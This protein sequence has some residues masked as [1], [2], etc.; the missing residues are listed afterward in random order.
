MNSVFLMGRLT[1]DPDLKSTTNGNS[2]CSFTIAV[3]RKYKNA[4]GE[5][6]A[7]FI[8]CQAWRATAENI[9]KY[10]GKG[11]KIAVTGRLQARS[12]EDNDGKR[13]YATEVVVEGFEF[14]ESK[15]EGQVTPASAE[16]GYAG[17]F[18]APALAENE[19]SLPFDL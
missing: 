3:D 5:R 13:Q 15:R 16:Q 19:T 1:A 6:E 8:R 4:N 11:S 10:F 2:V 14:C 17:P 18:S 12:W 9:S 7:D